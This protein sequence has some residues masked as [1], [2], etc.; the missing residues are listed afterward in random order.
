MKG[1][2]HEKKIKEVVGCEK[3]RSSESVSEKV[4]DHT[5]GEGCGESRIQSHCY[6]G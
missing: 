3:E 5:R 4:V 2:C 6:D 1:Q